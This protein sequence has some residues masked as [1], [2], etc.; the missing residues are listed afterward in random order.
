MTL[1]TGAQVPLNVNPEFVNP[2][3]PVPFNFGLRSNNTSQGGNPYQG[4][5]SDVQLYIN[6]LS[7]NESSL[8]YNS[9]VNSNFTAHV[10]PPFSGSIQVLPKVNP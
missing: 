4:A 10:G 2:V 7:D 3:N 1:S 5:V 9:M 6:G 8:I